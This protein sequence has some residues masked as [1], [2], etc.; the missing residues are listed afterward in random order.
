MVLSCEIKHFND[1]C[2]GTCADVIPALCG[3]NTKRYV[4]VVNTFNNLINCHSSLIRYVE[5]YQLRQ[6]T[7]LHLQLYAKVNK[8]KF[9]PLLEH[10]YHFLYLV[11][12]PDPSHGEEGSGYSPNVRVVPR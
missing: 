7:N 1:S 12:E 6:H 10:C 3:S 4:P 8:Q 9:M 5:K 11:S 2:L